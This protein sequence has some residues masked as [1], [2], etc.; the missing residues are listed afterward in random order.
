MS[1]LILQQLNFLGEGLCKKLSEKYKYTA[2]NWLCLLTPSKE[3][4][5]FSNK[6]LKILLILCY[7]T[8]PD[9]F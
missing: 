5:R 8:Y 9:A 1:P 7:F 2:I 3:N 4:Y 6:D